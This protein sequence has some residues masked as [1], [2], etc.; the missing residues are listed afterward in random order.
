MQCVRDLHCIQKIRNGK[1]PGK[2]ISQ[3]TGQ[4][5]RNPRFL[6]TRQAPARQPRRDQNMLEV[7]LENLTGSAWNYSRQDQGPGHRV[8]HGGSERGKGVFCA[9]QWGGILHGSGG[10]LFLPFQRLHR[11]EE[12]AGTGIGLATVQKIMLRH[13]GEVWAEGEPGQAAT[14]YFT[15]LQ[16]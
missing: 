16:P 11:E 8:W 5:E 1:Y 10:K 9:R 4:G 3:S 15:L 7:V 6:I 12:F 13:G 2:S 14:F